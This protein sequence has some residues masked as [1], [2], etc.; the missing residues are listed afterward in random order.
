[1]AECPRELYDKVKEYGEKVRLSD[2]EE[3]W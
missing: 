2:S 1:V 3:F